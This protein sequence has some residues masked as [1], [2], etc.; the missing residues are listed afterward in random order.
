MPYCNAASAAESALPN[1]AIGRRMKRALERSR[2]AGVGA[3]D[4]PFDIGPWLRLGLSF[5][6]TGDV[7]GLDFVNAVL[8][9]ALQAERRRARRKRRPRA[10]LRRPARKD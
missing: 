6:R 2:K 8:Q 1:S 3:P 4:K 5:A 10:P 9:Q 7:D